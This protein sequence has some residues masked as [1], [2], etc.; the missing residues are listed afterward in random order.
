MVQRR[1]T[2]L[3]KKIKF[4]I[5]RSIDQS[6][7][8]V[9]WTRPWNCSNLNLMIRGDSTRFYR[10]SSLQKRPSFPSDLV[11]LSLSSMRQRSILHMDDH[12]TVLL[13]KNF[14]TSFDFNWSVCLI[15]LRA[16]S[17]IRQNALIETRCDQSKEFYLDPPSLSS[18]Y[19]MVFPNRFNT[20][21]GT[22][23]TYI[24]RCL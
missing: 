11:A 7:L 17:V 9:T 10:S 5:D 23:T 2:L 20:S 6:K 4:E 14:A 19:C 8:C 18:R 24:Q 12:I 22:V 15:S 21:S 3:P 13:L 16:R 1:T